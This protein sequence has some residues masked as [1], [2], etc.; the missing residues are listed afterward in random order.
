MDCG[1][2]LKFESAALQYVQEY[3]I[4][5]YE[6]SNGEEE[7]GWKRAVWVYRERVMTLGQRLNTERGS[8]PRRKGLGGKWQCSWSLRGRLGRGIAS[9]STVWKE[10]LWFF[11]N[12]SPS[13]RL[14]LILGP[15]SFVGWLLYFF[16]SSFA[17]FSSLFL[18]LLLFRGWI[19][20]LD[21]L[22]FFSIFY[23]FAFLLDFLEYFLQFSLPAFPLNFSC[24]IF[25][26][27]ELF[28]LRTV[29]F[30]SILGM[31]SVVWVVISSIISLW[32]LIIWSF[33]CCLYIC[34]KSQ[35]LFVVAL[36]SLAC[37][38]P[39][40]IVGLFMEGSLAVCASGNWTFTV[41]RVITGCY[42]LSLKCCI[43]SASR[44]RSPMRRGPVKVGSL[45]QWKWLI[46]LWMRLYGK[47][48]PKSWSM[49]EA[50]MTRVSIPEG[51]VL[52]S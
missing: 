26:F 7:E 10:L 1:F 13:T 45:P 41:S 38:F 31:F 33:F 47:Q 17:I 49:W 2:F 43:F 8:L 36:H 9:G 11:L 22:I 24:Y 14:R 12:C 34:K 25:N 3:K 23:F 37:L 6:T 39:V 20:W 44:E 48:C 5:S 28:D 21:P 51:L 19:S 4:F 32:I 42:F 40:T 35:N 16:V 30:Y 50:P 52:V 15:Q 18:G 29:Y 46:S 27:P